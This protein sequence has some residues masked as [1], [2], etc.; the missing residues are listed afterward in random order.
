[1]GQKEQLQA[2]TSGTGHTLG[3]GSGTGFSRSRLAM[4]WGQVPGRRCLCCH[5]HVDSSGRK[6][7]TEPAQPKAEGT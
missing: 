1:M 2:V 5:R 7:L 4:G 6:S 3:T